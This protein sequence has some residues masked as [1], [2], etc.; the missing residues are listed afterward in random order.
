MSS[1]LDCLKV[2]KYRQDNKLD[3]Y[4]FG[5]GANMIPQPDYLVDQ[6]KEYSHFKDY[7]TPNGI[8]PLNKT[9]K[10]LYSND[11]YNVTNVVFGNGSKE[12]I[13]LI[14][15]IH[16][17]VIFHIT[18][19]WVSYIEQSVLLD[20]HVVNINTSINNNFKVLPD[21]LD[22]ILSQYK[23]E[24]KLIIFNNPNNPTGVL[25][26]PIETK[27]IADILIKHNTIIMIQ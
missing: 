3:I 10:R 15:K 14:Q 18:P 25:Y 11:T 19:C 4:D 20:N 16:K 6:L 26:N 1:T 13:Y 5:L 22:S 21:V 17:G 24:E 2:I 7:T 9:I 23:H 12:L 27:A 8:E